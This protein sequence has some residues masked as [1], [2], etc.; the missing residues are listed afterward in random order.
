MEE[1]QICKKRLKVRKALEKEAL[2]QSNNEK[3]YLYNRERLRTPL[4]KYNQKI[5]DGYTEQLKECNKCENVCY[6]SYNAINNTH[7]HGCDTCKMKTEKAEG[8]FVNDDLAE[9]TPYEQLKGHKQ[10]KAEELIDETEL[11]S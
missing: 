10:T 4:I 7:L 5:K 9:T 11:T 2:T 1:C 8:R 6:S 3:T